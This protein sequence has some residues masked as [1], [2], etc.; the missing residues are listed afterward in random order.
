MLTLCR[1]LDNCHSNTKAVPESKEQRRKP[2]LEG[3]PGWPNP[4]PYS[5]S[6]PDSGRAPMAPVGK[7]K[8]TKGELSQSRILIG[9]A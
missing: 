9:Q 6:E 2:C 5:I 3:G 1:N 7:P 4:S 8:E